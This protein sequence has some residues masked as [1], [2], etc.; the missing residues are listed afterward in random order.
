MR[1]DNFFDRLPLMDKN[2]ALKYII[3]GLLVAIIA[4]SILM[5]SM[6]IAGMSGTWDNL[7]MQYLNEQYWAGNIGYQEYLE[8]AEAIDKAVLWMNFQPLILGNIARVFVNIG[9]VFMV[10]GFLGIAVNEKIDEQ[11]R[12]VCLIFGGAILFVIIFTTMFTQIAIQVA[13]L[14][15]QM[16]DKL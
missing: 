10:I 14:I 6:T 16:N 7:A 9:L 12:K 15:F 8:Q 4:G 2:K 13:W 11:T 1:D 5:L 3:Y